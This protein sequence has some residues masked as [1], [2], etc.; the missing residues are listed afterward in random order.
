MSEDY[1]FFPNNF[2]IRVKNVKYLIKLRISVIVK[3]EC[4]LKS[5]IYNDIFHFPSNMNPFYTFKTFLTNIIYEKHFD[6]A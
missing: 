1:Y 3:N 4:F 2:V 5:K 6:K